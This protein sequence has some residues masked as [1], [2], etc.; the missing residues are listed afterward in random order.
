[1]AKCFVVLAISEVRVGTSC[2]CSVNVG[3][4]AIDRWT[5][6]AALVKYVSSDLSATR[7]ELIT[8]TTHMTTGPPKLT[9]HIV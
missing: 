1:M 4:S 6:G 7:F 9:C 2:D 3:E 8:K 5:E